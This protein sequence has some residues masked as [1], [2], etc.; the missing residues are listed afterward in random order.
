MSDNN[1]PPGMIWDW[2]LEPDHKARRLSLVVY[3]RTIEQVNGIS[4]IIEERD[5]QDGKWGPVSVAGHTVGEWI[6]IMEAE[7][8]EAKEALIKGGKG[9]DSVLSEIT[10]VAA[11]A[12]A[13][14]EQHGTGEIEG[15]SV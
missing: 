9:R 2:V 4:S 15:R 13:C 1:I 8:A 3:P 12:L 7:L 10:Q 11:V 14:L 5:F 6:L